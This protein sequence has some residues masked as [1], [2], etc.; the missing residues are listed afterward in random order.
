MGTGGITPPINLAQLTFTNNSQNYVV[1]SD[2]NFSL[3]QSEAI[4]GIP[5]GQ[6]YSTVKIVDIL[7]DCQIVDIQAFRNYPGYEW[8]PVDG[9]N[10][11]NATSLEYIYTDAFSGWGSTLNNTLNF[12]NAIKLKY[13]GTD[14]FKGWSSNTKGVNFVGATLL[15]SIGTE[16]FSGWV[17][18]KM[19]SDLVIPSNI[20]NIGWIAFSGWSSNP[21][22]VDL[23][24]ATGLTTIG[25]NAFKGW[26]SVSACLVTIPSNVSNMSS[27]VFSDWTSNT[28]GVNLTNATS[29]SALDIDTFSNWNS[30]KMSTDLVIP[31]HFTH[32][33]RYAFSRWLNNT[34]GV[35]LAG[36]TSLTTIDDF[37]FDDWNAVTAC[38]VTIP[39]NVKIVG[40]YSF[41]RW[42]SNIN[43]VDFTNASSL[44]A[45]GNRAFYDWR[46]AQ[47]SSDLVIP[48]SVTTIGESAFYN[49]ISN[50]KGVNLTNATYLT[51]IRDSAFDGWKNADSDTDL[52]MPPNIV[53]I[54]TAS[55]R[56]WNSM[57]KIVAFNSVGLQYIGTSAVSEV[58]NNFL[59]AP[60]RGWT[61][62]D[63]ASN[64]IIPATV[65]IIGGNS[66]YGWNTMSKGV[67]FSDTIS[68]I[69]SVRQLTHIGIGAF[70]L[71][72]NATMTQNI[73]IPSS[74]VFI[75]DWA[76]AEWNKMAF[77]MTF[78]SITPPVFGSNNIFINWGLN[79]AN[80]GVRLT[81]P[82]GA[83]L[84][85]WKTALGGPTNPNYVYSINGVLYASIP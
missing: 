55:F 26:T 21:N 3:S 70:S 2:S 63:S 32:I 13:I 43:G 24:G 77:G 61:H 30:A 58:V 84:S 20:K 35:N 34:K 40:E 12:S 42:K 52:L 16:A 4:A 5:S 83:N 8:N 14:A 60:F 48:S 81:V 36:A 27:S 31:S 78:N 7:P 46:S 15:K 71:W 33:G 54:N 38:T 1:D 41:F 50:P 47:M 9:V 45:I 73:N 74:V 29:L 62:A 17:S 39:S 76:F 82:G 75:G 51:D 49:W 37:A 72:Y 28:S 85:I 68:G 67:T 64:L 22:G 66:F 18:A 11:N 23:T 19:S 57:T 56:N 53:M 65:K 79:T 44:S 6:S 25:P 80:V 10:F 69:P 59:P